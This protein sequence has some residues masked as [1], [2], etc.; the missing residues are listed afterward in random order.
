MIA[1][2]IDLLARKRRRGGHNR[3]IKGERYLEVG[4]QKR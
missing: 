2:L 3:L 4:F 1:R